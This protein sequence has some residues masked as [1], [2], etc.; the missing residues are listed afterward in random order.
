MVFAVAVS[1]LASGLAH[2]QSSELLGK[3]LDPDGKPV[4]GVEITAKNVM[5]PDRQYKGTTDKK[6]SFYVTGLIYTAQAQD[7]DI[8]IKGEGWIPQSVKVLARDSQ[9]NMYVNDQSKLSAT[10]ASTQLKLKGFSEVRM[11]YV[12]KPGNAATEAA[13][14]AEATAAAAAA[15]AAAAI[16]VEDTYSLAVEKLKSGDT[17]GSVDLFKKAVDEQPDDW[18]RRDVYAKV[19][20]KLDRQGDATIQAGKAAQLAPDKA[21]PLI[22][23]TDI[24]LAR[25][26][27]DKAGESIAK[28]QAA[29][30]D[31]LKV[32]ERAA[33]VAAIDGRV[34]DAIALS[35]KV[36]AMKPDNTEV[37]VSLAAL[38]NR[39]KQPKKAEEVL[40]RVVA[41]DPA[42]AH[43][44]FYNVG[45]VIENNDDA[46]EADHRKAIDAF[47]KAIDLKPDY[48][49]AHRDLGFALLRTGD[50]LAARKELQKYVE[51]E[52]NAKD[53]AE[54]K[55]TIKSL[56]SV[57]SK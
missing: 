50:L 30:P 13:A 56:D 10:Q 38:Y 53:T 24:Y 43:R 1:A 20:L 7:W 46:T 44:T 2:A 33:A 22:T 51:L 39:N 25:G 8:S 18:E 27:N 40:N 36:I 15:A 37:L 19:L 29:E 5:F 26:L 57:K 52:P 54:I 49:N 41:L 34:P 45:V 21:A 48:A 35:E 9:K 42:N 17:E 28:A 3:V 4:V 12:M 55:A 23:L 47:K 6:G 32:L 14:A 11:E 16:P 31:N